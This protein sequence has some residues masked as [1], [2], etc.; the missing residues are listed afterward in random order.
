[1]FESADGLLTPCTRQNSGRSEIVTVSEMTSEPDVTSVD[2]T[3]DVPL[4]NVRPFSAAQSAA[5]VWAGAGRPGP[6][7]AT[8]MMH[9]SVMAP[10]APTRKAVRVVA[11]NGMASL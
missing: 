2:D 3:I 11:L 8:A 9:A 10:T 4:S 5:C 6:C 7:A 1:M